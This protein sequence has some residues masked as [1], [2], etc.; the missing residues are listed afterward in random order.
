VSIFSKTQLLTLIV[1]PLHIILVKL[2]LV[3]FGITHNELEVMISL[4]LMLEKSQ[5]IV[6][7]KIS[8]S[9]FKGMDK[10]VIRIK[11]SKKKL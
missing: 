11:L 8:L 9:E 1:S 3:N 6:L 5:L 7:N 10:I 2:Q 4:S